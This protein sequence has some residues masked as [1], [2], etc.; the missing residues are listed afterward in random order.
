MP[1]NFQNVEMD[2]TAS[3]TFSTA[4]GVALR[5][6]VAWQPWIQ[7]LQR[8]ADTHEVWEYLDI[9]T[10][11]ILQA[12]PEPGRST[13]QKLQSIACSR[14]AMLATPFRTVYHISGL[15]KYLKVVS[16]WPSLHFLYLG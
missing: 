2:I 12:P 3:S 11:D 15:R 10:E 9:D 13:L 4:V 5:P 8:L 1:V 16:C 7:W 14:Q 6:A